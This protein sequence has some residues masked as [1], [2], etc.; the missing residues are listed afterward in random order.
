MRT[1]HYRA[2]MEEW[3]RIHA[4]APLRARNGSDQ[5]AFN[6]LLLDTALRTRHFERE[7]IQFPSFQGKWADW[8]EAALLHVAGGRVEVKLEQLTG[9]FY[10]R[11]LGDP[12]GLLLGLMDP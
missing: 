5:P 6:R 9:F 1:E 3:A 4:G 11:Y 2:V 8:R 10:S 12:T 7:E